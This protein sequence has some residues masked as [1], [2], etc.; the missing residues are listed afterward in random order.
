M[1][2]ASLDLIEEAGMPAIRAKSVALAEF[3]LEAVE[4]L[5]APRGVRVVSPRESTSRGGHVTVRHPAFRD[6]M[7][8]LW[9]RGVLA[10]FREPESIRIGMSP[11][12]T[13]FAEAHRGLTVLAALLAEAV[14]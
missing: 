9:E 12:S 14:A 10:D 8:P 11:L 4:A 7:G 2:A 6:L 3:A 13:S 1:L 5:L